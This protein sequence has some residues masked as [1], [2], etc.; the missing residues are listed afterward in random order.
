MKMAWRDDNQI[1]LLVNGDEFYPSV[2][3][4]IR[5]ARS[6]VILETFIWHEDN[7]GYQLQSALLTAAQNGVSIDVTVDDYGSH[8]L[9]VVFL[10]PLINAGVRVRFY[11]PQPRF[12]GMRTNL[13]R[14]LHRKIVVVDGEM[15]YIGGINYSA[16]QMID[17]GPEAKQDYAVKVRGPIV[18]DIYRNALAMLSGKKEPR[19]WWRHRFRRPIR[20]KN[21]GDA[22]ALFVYR[23][24]GEH[25]NDI[26]K[27]YLYMLRQAKR[28]IIIANAYFFP[29]YRLLRAMRSASRRNVR[30]KLIIQGHPD[31]PIVR[32]GARLLY[33]YL[34]AAG[35]EIYE[36]QRRPLHGKVAVQ[37]DHWT[38]VGSSNLDPLSLALNLEANL[39]IHDRDFNQQL[40]D[41]LQQIINDDCHLIDA[42]QLPKRTHWQFIKNVVVFHF[43]RHFPAMVGWFPAH[44]PRLSLVRS[45]ESAT[46]EEMK[47][48][49]VET[50]NKEI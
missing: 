7:V 23:D 15:A 31:I 40:R 10:A 39:F 27:H 45:S 8:D 41:N 9:S 21:P 35:V 4:A 47:P 14:R 48:E 17:Y 44:V 24:N 30:V 49:H 16:E 50:D 22:Q 20:N 1:E 37:D 36:Y 25:R 13:F 3:T 18:D 33:R 2:F 26:E 12:F 38:T 34:I 42:D 32:T 46:L 43:L 28:E 6:R 29:G 19:Q 5:Q 11:D